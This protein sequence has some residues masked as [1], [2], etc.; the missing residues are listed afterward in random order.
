MGSFSG[1]REVERTITLPDGKRLAGT[2]AI[3]S[4]PRSAVIF[5]HGTGSSRFSPRNRAVASA[6]NRGG[7]CTLLMDLLT[8]EEE[9]AERYTRQLRFDVDML[10]ERLAIAIVLMQ[11]EFGMPIGVF[12]ASTGAAAALIAAAKEP[13]RVKAVVSRGGRPDLAGA[14]LRLVRTPTL[15]IVGELDTAVIELNEQA[16]SRM[17]APVEIK[18]VPGASHLFEEPGTLEE[19]AALAR[20]WFE[21]HLSP[22]PNS[23]TA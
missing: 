14:A 9:E 6:L 12:G 7:F 21:V 23:R 13:N 3:P 4:D 16:R 15:L 17:T 19:V 10:A 8:E 1:V 2:L 20:A 5:A 18:L 11:E 22:G